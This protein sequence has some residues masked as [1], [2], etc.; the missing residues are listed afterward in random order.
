MDGAGPVAHLDEHGEG[1]THPRCRLADF[2]TAE[3]QVE[4]RNQC[5]HLPPRKPGAAAE[6]DAVPEQ[7][8]RLIVVAF[9]GRYVGDDSD[10]DGFAPGEPDRAVQFEAFLGQRTSALD[11]VSPQLLDGQALEDDRHASCVADGAVVVETQLESAIP[12]VVLAE[13]DRGEAWTRSACARR[14]LG[15]SSARPSRS[16][17]RR[18]PSSGSLVTQ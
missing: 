15:A 5:A 14:L 13:H 9:Q 3:Q 6:I 7:L 11:V 2:A 12:V 8:E 10:R 4:D 17:S 16:P 18:R 1:L